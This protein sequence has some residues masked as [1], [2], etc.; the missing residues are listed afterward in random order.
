M[1][2]PDTLS[3]TPQEVATALQLPK[4][5]VMQLCRR[6]ILPARKL[7]RSWRILRASLRDVFPQQA[8]APAT[9]TGQEVHPNPGR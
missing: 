8:I 3:M 7:G 6:G 5:T 4:S 9:G 1:S 2:F